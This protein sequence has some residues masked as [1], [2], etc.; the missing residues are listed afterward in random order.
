MAEKTKAV[1]TQVSEEALAALRESYP[2]EQYANRIQLPR[3]SMASQDKTKET[4]AGKN[5]KIEVVT[6]AGTFFTEIQT[7]EE[8]P[9]TGKKIWAKNEIG[10]S[11]EGIILY[12][13]KQLRMFDNEVYTS[14][15]IYDTDEEVIPLWCDKQEV[16]R[17]TPAELKAKY[18][19]KDPRTSKIK[20]KLEDNRVL[21]VK[22]VT[23]GKVYQLSIRGTSMYSFFTY[24]RK[25]LV[26]SVVTAFGSEA[27]ENGAISWN[28]MTFKALRKLNQK[29][30][31]E[32][33]DAVND[34]RTTV[35][36]EKAQF[37][38]NTP[39]SSAD[40]DQAELVTAS[41]KTSF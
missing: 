37:G 29:E 36:A 25:V 41:G 21:Y 20:S 1:S 16:A 35:A 7:D 17:G 27:K 13:R 32:V 15:P 30:V 11:F 22:N 39:T 31:E 18:Q 23:D 14:S 33:L 4:G 19:F 9:D 3:I 38:G 24:G 6:A 10:E 2:V 5:K 34:I 8:D 28:Q 12:Q 26:P 40:V